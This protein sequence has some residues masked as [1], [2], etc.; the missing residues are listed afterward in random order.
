MCRPPCWVWKRIENSQSWLVLAGEENTE[1]GGKVRRDFPRI[2][3]L[4]LARRSRSCS[5]KREGQEHR[6]HG[7]IP[8]MPMYKYNDLSLYDRK[9]VSATLGQQLLSKQE[10]LETRQFL[11]IAL[12]VI[13]GS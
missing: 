11:E 2:R 7:C 12:P 3:P 4:S 13:S 9:A 8:V 5:L 10:G 6:A 1:P